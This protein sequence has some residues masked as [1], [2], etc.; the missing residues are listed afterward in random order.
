M[1]AVNLLPV[2]DRA[3][4]PAE[5]SAGSSRLVLGGLVVLLLAVVAVVFTQNQA[6]DRKNEI[7]KADQ[8]ATAAQQRA[9]ALGSFGKFTAIKE[10]RV[11]SVRSLAGD[12][13]DWERFMR[14]LA[15]VLPKD[16][17]LT[18]VKASTSGT[19]GAST[20]SS[21]PASTGTAGAPS[22]EIAGC[23]KSQSAV[24]ETMVRL[25]NLDRADDVTLADS[26][27]AT[28]GSTGTSPAPSTPDS[29]SQEGC[30]NGFKFDATV[31]F[32]QDTA[33]SGQGA[34]RKVPAALGGGS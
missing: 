22:A 14:E 32:T 18:D 16:T 2:G 13:F 31:T 5:I 6:T 28:S 15:L 24:A 20:A 1:R 19:T 30:G 21:S 17:W 8:E 23:A 27:K 10:Q 25:R 34:Q 9:S 4:G 26:S 3:K 12:R 29:A 33:A 11:S 7:A